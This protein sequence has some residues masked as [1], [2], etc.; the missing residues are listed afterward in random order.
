MNC[1]V[2]ARLVFRRIYFGVLGPKRARG[3]K[4]DPLDRPTSEV[5]HSCLSIQTQQAWTFINGNGL[6]ETMRISRDWSVCDKGV[7]PF[8][9]VMARATCRIGLGGSLVR[10]P[11]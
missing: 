5:S 10:A 9:L 3:K 7:S 2:T 4:G 1:Q 8:V 6:A 11:R